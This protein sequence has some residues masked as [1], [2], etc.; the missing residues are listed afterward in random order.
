MKTAKQ[1]FEEL[2]WDCEKLD[3]SDKST[4]LIDREIRTYAETGGLSGND[5]YKTYFSIWFDEKNIQLINYKKPWKEYGIRPMF[6]IKTNGAK[7]KNGDKC[8]TL[9][10]YFG[11]LV[12]SYANYNL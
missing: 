9:T 3:L 2:G 1:M 4:D 10:I 11:Y 12:L 7:R 5:T 8:F 6:K